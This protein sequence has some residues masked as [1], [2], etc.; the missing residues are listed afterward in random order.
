MP[1][2]L[3]ETL[4]RLDALAPL[5]LAGAWDNVGLLLQGTG[6]IHR[7]GLAIDLTEPVADELLDADVDLIV[8]Y[9][10]PLFGGKKRLTEATPRDRTLLRLIRAGVHVYSPHSALDAAAR[11]MADW[12][13]DPFG[14]ASEV[15]PIEPDA[16]DPTVG[17]GR[18]A[19]LA[20]PVPLKT[21]LPTIA[22]HLGLSH[23]RVAGDE[24]AEVSTVAV[25]PGAGGSLFA[26]I[27]H[28]DLFLTGEMRHHDVL[29][30]VE[31]GQAVVLTDHTNTE[32]GY[33]PRLAERLEDALGLPVVRSRIDADPL[34]VWP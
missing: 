21:L 3:D 1:L 4:R 11:G 7:V 17:A 12:L 14:A 30:R 27:R 20:S 26:G 9:H 32:R 18:R 15:H 31:A 5:R 28:A 34:R 25:C 33:L 8:S 19:T 24:E 23:L 29:A 16:V 6:P 13:L 22:E 2:A 10:P